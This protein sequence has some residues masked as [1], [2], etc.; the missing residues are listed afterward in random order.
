ME[1]TALPRSA[2]G[3][4]LSAGVLSVV[5]AVW[6]QGLVAGHEYLFDGLLLYAVALTLSARFLDVSSVAAPLQDPGGRSRLI[7]WRLTRPVFVTAILVVAA[8]L[9]ALRLF[10]ANA[11][12]SVAWLLYAASVI[13]AP[14]TVWLVVGRPRSWS[15]KGW[16]LNDAAGLGAVLLVG[17]AFRLFRIDSLPFGLW[18]DEAYSGLQ[19]LHI[20]NDPSYRPV[21]V[22]AMAQEPALFWYFAIPFVHLFGPSALGLRMTAVVGGLIGIVAIYLLAR[23]LLGRRVAIVSAFLLAVMAWHVDFSR[24]AFNSIWSV[25]FDALAAFLLLRG[26]RVGSLT[27]FAL[28]G[29]VLGLGANMYYTTRLVPLV[30]ILFLIHR[31]AAERGRFLRSQL[32]GLVVLGVTT[33][34][35]ISPLVQ[36]AYLHPADFF[37][38]T[39]QVTIFKEVIHDHSYLPLIDNLRKHLGMF[40]YQGDSNGRHNLPKAPMLDQVTGALFA[41]GLLIALRKVRHSHYFFLLIWWLVMLSGGVFS[42]AFEAPQSLRTIDE[43]T[44]VAILASLPVVGLWERLSEFDLGALRLDVAVG[45]LNTHQLTMP[46]VTL[47]VVG[48]LLGAAATNYDRYFDQ[49]AGNFSSWS[50]YS[51]G[52]TIV[53]NQVKR[54]G[55]DYD[56]Y[57]D[58]TFVDHPT[59]EF[60]SGRKNL[61]SFSPTAQLPLGDSKNVAVFLQPYQTQ[62]VAL[63]RTLYP[64][65][66]VE[67][68]RSPDGDNIVLYSAMVPR[69]QIEAL[70]GVTASYFG[71]VD[72]TGSPV[73]WERLPYPATEW[74]TPGLPKPPFFTLWEGTLVAPDYGRYRLRL[75]GPR[76]A[77]LIVDGHR[78]AGASEEPEVTLARG[79]H[80][81]EV[82]AA[83]NECT[84]MRLLWQPPNAPHLTPIPRDRVFVPPVSNHGLLGSYYSNRNWSGDP[85]FQRID[86]FLTTRVQLL[87]LPRPYS[88][89]WVGKIDAPRSGLYSLAT[90]S[91]DTSWVYLDGQLVTTNEGADRQLREG[92]IRLD[93]GLHDLRVRFRDETGY[94]FIRVYWTPPGGERELLPSDRLY[95][96]EG[97]YPP[98]LQLP[99][100]QESSP[101]SR[102]PTTLR[103]GAVK[104][105]FSRS[106]GSGLLADPRDMAVSAEGHIYV[107]DTA[108]KRV[109]ILNSDGSAA[110]QLESTFVQPFGVAVSSDSR[111]TVLDSLGKDPILQFGSHGE[112]VGRL[113]S[114]AGAY[115]PRGLFVD[116]DGSIYLADTGRGRVLKLSPAGQVVGEFR[117]GGQL[118]QPVAVAVDRNGVLYVVDGEKHQLLVIGSDDKLLRTWAIAVSTTF[119]APHVALGPNGEI[120]V[121]N[122][123]GGTIDIYDSQ[124]DS[125]GRVGGP[126]GGDAQFGLPTGV[127]VDAQERL[128]VADT[129]NKRVEMWTIR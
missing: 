122:P 11:N 44:V 39:D 91:A 18:W 92:T 16:N 123:N 116:A 62:S 63:L 30:L 101:Q 28:A 5:L 113:G 83:V 120:Y 96:P 37:A 86:P 26:L 10:A 128:W 42:L 94:T 127:Q 71:D 47:A 7:S 6:G 61:S 100:V 46:V 95:P 84:P 104:E 50:A 1:A 106:F 52:E 31:L 129:R 67:A 81:L 32:V 93:A 68:H 35:T 9:L 69:S 78:I 112:V 60:L 20:M 126:G 107:A 87:P 97:D 53:G 17:A 79:N 58:E 73:L 4:A 70:E 19:I 111:V 82:K 109:M 12:P 15:L 3:K 49:Q 125:I 72:G 56:V 75:D 114:S 51:A 121:S 14:L 21:Y 45:R 2:G 66:D 119:D 57:L 105:E 88:V 76:G 40:L 117:G 24:I 74:S 85:T 64:Q 38:R 110:G 98:P 41:I 33:L 36:F 102:V 90:E 103:P 55:P 8:S 77:E 80:S 27:C 43:V 13:G 22:A 59:I 118:A 25:T 34:I 115:S 99:T 29:T 65:A 89:E 124:G 23:E 48:L 54:L 108:A